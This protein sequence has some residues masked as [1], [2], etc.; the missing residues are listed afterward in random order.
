M[1]PLKPLSQVDWSIGSNHS[2]S[3]GTV[4]VPLP[5]IKGYR[6]TREAVI[7]LRP[8]INSGQACRRV[9]VNSDRIIQ[10]D[11]RSSY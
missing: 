4:T 2:L 6:R 1:V 11:N 8:S 9:T 10:E 5:L 7:R 3:R